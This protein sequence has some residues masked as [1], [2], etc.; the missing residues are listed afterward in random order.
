MVLQAGLSNV[1][2][3][4][5]LS[6]DC[7]VGFFGGIR[8]GSDAPADCPAAQAGR[9][10]GGPVGCRDGFRATRMRTI[11]IW[12]RC[13]AQRGPPAGAAGSART[14]GTRRVRPRCST[15]P[16]TPDWLNQ[17]EVYFSIIQRKVITPNDFPDLDRL[18]RR[19]LEFQ[20]Y[21]EE[22]AH[23]FKWKFT[24]DDLRNVLPRIPT[25]EL[26]LPDAA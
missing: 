19:L 16:S 25:T 11:R 1:E 26:R 21:Y 18:E 4:E 12:R 13:A 5:D 22:T 9:G 3:V 20:R 14:A 7:A 24:R 2:L 8:P 15:R 17:V 23:P 10:G 6:R